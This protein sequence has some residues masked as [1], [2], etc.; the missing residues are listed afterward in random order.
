MNETATL[1]G[2]KGAGV[3]HRV[4][5]RSHN[6]HC[7]QRLVTT[8]I[9]EDRPESNLCSKCFY[10]KQEEQEQTSSTEGARMNT[11]AL[12]AARR[13]DIALSEIEEA[14]VQFEGKQFKSIEI[15]GTAR[16]GDSKVWV[17]RFEMVERCYLDSADEEGFD[18]RTFHI[19]AV[20]RFETEKAGGGIYRTP[21]SVSNADLVRTSETE[22]TDRFAEMIENGA[23]EVDWSA[24][25]VF[26]EAELAGE[27]L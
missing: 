25:D 27:I 26:L 16:L 4:N 3:W 22:S 21:I 1:Y 20:E 2:R 18:R 10:R 5:T 24:E 15:V 8:Q 13:V 19:A 23:D 7:N 17:V 6:A 14:I 12:A 11:E 9:R